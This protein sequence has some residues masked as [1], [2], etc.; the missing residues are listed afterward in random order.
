[1]S[2]EYCIVGKEEIKDILNLYMDEIKNHLCDYK[3]ND[4]YEQ[5]FKFLEE[6]HGIHTDE[7]TRN[8]A[9]WQLFRNG[10]LGENTSK[11]AMFLLCNLIAVIVAVSTLYLHD[12]F[13]A[14]I[15]LID[16]E[17]G[18]N[19]V[20]NYGH[21]LYRDTHVLALIVT[22]FFNPFEKHNFFNVKKGS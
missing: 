10:I 22:L 8:S 4:R 3:N 13:G 14:T 7:K 17:Q 5:T 21:M 12:D 9:Y 20:I 19:I 11:I 16:K 15:T 1:M 2:K 18:E 6:I